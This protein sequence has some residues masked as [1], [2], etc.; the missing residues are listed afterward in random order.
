MD[1]A[2]FLAELVEQARAQSILEVVAVTTAILYLLLAIQQRIAC[3]FFAAISTS[4]YIYLFV[5]VKLYM[6]SVLN[7]YYLG[8]AVYGWYVWSRKR[9][10]E[11]RRPVTMWPLRVHMIAIVAITLVAA[12]S[13]HWLS[14]N[15]DAAYPYVDSMT[16]W[17]ALWATY[18]VAE[19]VL[20]N[21]WYWFVIDSVSVFIYWS[22]DL[23]LTSILFVF[24][25]LIIP[26]GIY[27]WTRSMRREQAS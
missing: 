10:D 26:F 12:F 4:I 27:S 1:V 3:W 23:Q 18:L 13:G 14:T 17:F 11:A 16:T 24:Y 9:P 5:E 21:W 22:R 7:L 15:T 20:E 6:E 25:V 8:M 19:K 2:H